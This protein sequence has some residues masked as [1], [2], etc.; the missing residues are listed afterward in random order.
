MTNTPSSLAAELLAV[1]ERLAREAGDMALAGRRRG[2][3]NVSTKTSR[4]DMVTEYDKA[5]EVLIYEGLRALRPH[6]SIVGEEGA[7]HAGTNDIT[8]FID[9]IDGTSNFLYDIPLWAVSIGARQDGIAIAGAVYVAAAGEMFTAIRGGG[10]HL[11]GSPIACNSDARLDTALV[12]TGFSYAPE[13]RPIQA[14]RVARMIGQIRDIRRFGAAAVD[15]CYVACGRLDGYFE[16]N[17][18][19]WDIAAG[20]LIARE[21]GCLTGDFSG[22]PIRPAETMTASPAIFAT[23]GRLIVNST[24]ADQQ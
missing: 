9:P 17:L 22:G 12:A 20:D 14:R 7:S 13:S 10:A 24:G 6:D 18:H 11:N 21:A 8:W 23:L 1:A 2:L 4:T 3:Q 15:M 16:E 19:D 5:S